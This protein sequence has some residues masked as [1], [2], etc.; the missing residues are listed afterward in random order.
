[1]LHA[2]VVVSGIEY[3]PQSCSVAPMERR[4]GRGLRTSACRIQFP[5]LQ[6][7]NGRVSRCGIFLEMLVLTFLVVNVV[8]V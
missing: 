8:R 4:V 7:V 1:M 6:V 3:I 2:D 5:T